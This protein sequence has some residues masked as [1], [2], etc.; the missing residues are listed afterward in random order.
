MILLTKQWH[1]C[2]R[3]A[4][5]NKTRAAFTIRR[6]LGLLPAP[7]GD[8]VPASGKFIYL[9]FDDGPCVHTESL[10]EVLARY[11]VKAT[12]FVTKHDRAADLL[13]RIAAGGHTIGNHT[14]NH[15]YQSLYE[16][17]ASFLDAL[18]E[19]ER[20]ILDTTG[21][22]PVLFRFPGGTASIDH[23]THRPGMAHRLTELVQES[24]YR[25]YDWDLDSRD[26]AGAITP[27]RVYRNVISGIRGRTHTVVLQHDL[28]KYST[29]AVEAIIVWGLRNGY[30]F[31]PLTTDSPAHL[32]ASN[33]TSVK[34][35]PSE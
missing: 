4:W 18:T 24:G 12:F 16:S 13:P 2:C 10:L 35:S 23:L 25:I 14:A 17:E 20:I 22:R 8:D 11:H 6:F 29:D 27:G 19:M 28:K 3:V 30:T 1:K 21:I 31:L 5:R 15:H 26:T 34:K 7:Q 9:T 32:G 33:F